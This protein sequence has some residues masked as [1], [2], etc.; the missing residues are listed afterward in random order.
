MH[1]GPWSTQIGSLAR[2]FHYRYGYSPFGRTCIL[3]EAQS[4]TLR[5]GL[6]CLDRGSLC[7][8]LQ[9]CPWSTRYSSGRLLSNVLGWLFRRDP[10]PARCRLAVRRQPFDALVPRPKIDR[11]LTRAFL[12]DCYS[13][14]TIRYSTRICFRMG[15]ATRQRQ[16]TS[17]WEDGSCGLD[18]ARS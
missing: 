14:A 2:P 4:T 1:E 10:I 13:R 11:S 7:S 6:R 8:L 5:S 18:N 15:S 17:R 12:V 3:R 16:E 9:P